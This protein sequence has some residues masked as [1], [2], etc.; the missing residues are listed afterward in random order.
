[1]GLMVIQKMSIGCETRH[2]LLRIWN[3]R[4]QWMLGGPPAAGMQKLRPVSRAVLLLSISVAATI[5]SS[6]AV[7][8]ASFAM[9]GVLALFS[10][11]NLPA[12]AIMAI[13]ASALFCLPI[14]VVGVA[15]HLFSFN[16]AAI[17]EARC[18]VSV[19]AAAALCYSVGFV[20]IALIFERRSGG[21]LAQTIGFF[22]IQ[23]VHF[24]KILNEMILGFEA[25]KIKSHS[26]TRGGEVV[27]AQAGAL[28]R[29]CSHRATRLQEC[30]D[31]RTINIE[32]P[33]V[34]DPKPFRAADYGAIC[35]GLAAVLGSVLL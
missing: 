18:L 22:S 3:P 5:S 24:G 21:V 7:F 26:F 27:G 29:Q 14:A 6:P 23:A 1:M 28:F 34:P 35:A 33:P 15:C 17:M 12:M 8:L 10:D 11:L 32:A 31:L 25:R 9:V 16:H 30:H 13:V 2:F 19:W 4:S 20:R